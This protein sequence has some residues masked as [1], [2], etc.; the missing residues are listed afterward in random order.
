MN[1]IF[2][3]QKLQLAIDVE[4]HKLTKQTPHKRSHTRLL[5]GLSSE[6]GVGSALRVA[7]VFDPSTGF[8]EVWGE[9]DNC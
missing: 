9:Y 5:S 8:S 7:A 6:S 4:V 3:T 2:F 1:R